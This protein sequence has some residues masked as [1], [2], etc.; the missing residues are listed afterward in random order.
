VIHWKIAG[1]TWNY[2][3]WHHSTSLNFM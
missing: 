2:I 3:N 1:I